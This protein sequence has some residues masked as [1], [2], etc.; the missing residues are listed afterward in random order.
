MFLVWGSATKPHHAAIGGCRIRS[1]FGYA[2]TG[3]LVN[4]P[5]T[6]RGFRVRTGRRMTTI[7]RHQCPTHQHSALSTSLFIRRVVFPCWL[8]IR[9]NR[10]ADFE[11][12]WH[13]RCIFY[14]F[15]LGFKYYQKS[16]S[17]VLPN[18]PKNIK[19]KMDEWIFRFQKVLPSTGVVLK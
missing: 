11:N 6:S 9:A 19:K 1:V 12:K 7:F 10:N 2:L 15:L 16:T 5:V 18:F 17:E 3:P 13:I 14:E 8:N 4:Q